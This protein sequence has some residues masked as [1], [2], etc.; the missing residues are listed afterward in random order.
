MLKTKTQLRKGDRVALVYR[1]A[2]LLDFFAA[3]FGCLMAGLIAVPINGVE[4]I[5]EMKFI[6]A[7]SGATIALTTEHNHRTLTKSFAI[8]LHRLKHDE[9]RTKAEL[10][11]SDDIGSSSAREKSVNWPSGVVWWKTDNLV[12][13]KPKQDAIGKLNIDKTKDV[14]ASFTG[15][16]LS[17]LAYIEYTKA[18][19]GELKGVPVSHA[20]ILEQCRYIGHSLAAS[21][22]EVFHGKTEGASQSRRAVVMS[23]L[24]PRQQVGLIV[25]AW[26]GVY[27]DNH[28]VFLHS[29]VTT[30]PGLWERCIGRYGVTLAVGEY[31]G[32]KDLV[33]GVSL[34]P[35]SPMESSS[36]SGDNSMRSSTSSASSSQSSHSGNIKGVDAHTIVSSKHH[37]SRSSQQLWGHTNR[38]DSQST[39]TLQRFLVD[40]TVIEPLLHHSFEQEVLSALLQS[41]SNPTLDRVITPMAT[42]PEHGGMVLSI[43]GSSLSDSNAAVPS[44]EEVQ[45]RSNR[46]YHFLLDREAL[47]SNVVRVVAVAKE[48]IDRAQERGAILMESSGPVPAQGMYSALI[49]VIRNKSVWRVTCS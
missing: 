37:G 47:K 8:T 22:R 35:P 19:S 41:P 31:E 18:T 13:W 12:R 49:L 1:K 5:A 46:A 28:T 27:H 16:G 39:P 34:Y 30:R 26:M 32:I 4:E 11:T 45:S 6:L 17:D 7:N 25:G 36:S 24:E 20:V 33:K 23:W 14:P 38:T 43:R 42:L 44:S 40:T 3:F 21:G 9:A 48:A 10:R 29:G 2:E 15:V